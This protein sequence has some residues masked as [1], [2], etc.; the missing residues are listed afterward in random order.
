MPT[1]V[2]MRHG[3]TLWGEQNRFAGWGDTPLSETGKKEARKAAQSI[4]RSGLS[5]DRCY[6]SCLLRAQETLALMLSEMQAPDLAVRREWRLN[7]RHYGALQGETRSAMVDR[8]GNGA[9]VEWRRSFDAVPPPLADDD[10]RWIEQLGRMP[11]I[12]PV[13]QPHTESM[14]QA[15]ARV[16]PVWHESLAP[17]LRAGHRLL[18]VAHTSALRGLIR[19]IEG[20][21]DTDAA[22]FRIATAIPRVYALNDDLSPLESID[23]TEGLASSLR[24]WFTALKPRRVGWI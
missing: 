19:I 9:V 6:T 21:D 22:A 17:D 1:L 18:V 12:P 13:E 24:H 8:Y 16:A 4:V 3:A 20:L 2:L 11:Q 23:L 15:A 10:P 5:F 14:A 7:E